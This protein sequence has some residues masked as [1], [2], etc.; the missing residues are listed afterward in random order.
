V[1]AL[2][3]RIRDEWPGRNQAV[4]GEYARDSGP[5]GD[6]AS[7]DMKAVGNRRGLSTGGSSG[8]NPIGLV[9][10]LTN[11]LLSLQIICF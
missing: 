10:P 5:L 7:V 2:E 1:A 8:D 3:E 11:F 6:R 4:C 9:K